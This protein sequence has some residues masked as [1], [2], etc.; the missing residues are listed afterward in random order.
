MELYEGDSLKSFEKLR[1]WDMRLSSRQ[2]LYLMLMLTW[3]VD[4]NSDVKKNE[5]DHIQHVK[6][7]R[8]YQQTSKLD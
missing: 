8:G 4:L 7:L 2:L 5:W 6:T 3:T 1:I